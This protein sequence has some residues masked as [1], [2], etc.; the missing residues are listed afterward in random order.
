MMQ[1]S[2]ALEILYHHCFLTFHG[3]RKVYRN[4]EG[5]EFNGH[6]SSWSKLRILIYMEKNINTIK[7]NT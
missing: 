5:L 7:K 1:S 3:I 2:P 6:I 4:L